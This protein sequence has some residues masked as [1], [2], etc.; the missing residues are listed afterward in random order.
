M[1]RNDPAKRV[2]TQIGRGFVRSQY[3]ASCRLRPGYA[4]KSSTC[5]RICKYNIYKELIHFLIPGSLSMTIFIRR[6]LHGAQRGRRPDAAYLFLLLLQLYQQIVQIPGPK[7]PITLGLMAVQ[8]LM[9]VAPLLTDVGFPHG[10]PSIHSSCL[11][12]HAI[13]F[14]G[15][16]QRLFVSA[17]LHAD[18]HHLY[19]NMASLIWKGVKL[20]GSMSSLAYSSLLVELLVTSHSLVVISSY[21]LASFGP[22]EYRSL[23]QSLCAVGFSAVLFGMKVVLNH[24][25]PGW[26]SIFGI[27]LPTRFLCWGELIV[28]SLLFPQASFLGHLCGILAGFIHIKLSG[29]FVHVVYSCFVGERIRR[30]TFSGRGLSG[31]VEPA[32]QGQ[33]ST[34]N[35]APPMAPSAPAPAPPLSHHPSNEEVREIRLR[36]FQREL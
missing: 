10:F 20:E 32:Q 15:Q 3:D 22:S 16:W 6:G 30:T 23:P 18:E 14:K 9:F 7:P 5:H 35:R 17:F 4:P 27:P 24:S 28:S 21:L 2:M 29:P 13:I 19:Y 11:S 25:S 8:I 36:R 12:P 33:G 34:E 26:S 31:H 1:R